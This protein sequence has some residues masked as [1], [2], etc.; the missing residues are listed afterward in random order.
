VPGANREAGRYKLAV[1]GITASGESK[2]IGDTS[3]ELQ[4]QK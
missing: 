4:I 2:D 3:F 1:R